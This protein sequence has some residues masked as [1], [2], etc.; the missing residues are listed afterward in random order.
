MFTKNKAVYLY[1]SSD[2][3]NKVIP[4]LLLPFISNYF[5][6]EALFKYSNFILVFTLVQAL[7]S[8]PFVSFL[9]VNLIKDKFIY[10]NGL[11]NYL[12]FWFTFVAFTFVIYAL[13]II[14]ESDSSEVL[15]WIALGCLCSINTLYFSLLQI[16]S[17][18]IVFFISN[19][20]RISFFCITILIGI[21][22]DK[23]DLEFIIFSF[24]ASYMALSLVS[25][26]YVYKQINT[27][28]LSFN[29]NFFMNMMKF[30]LPLLP[31]IA[32]SP[33]R[34]ALDR[35]I[36]MYISTTAIAG[37]YAG[38]YQ[39]SS[40]VQMFSATIIKSTIPN[41]SKCLNESNVDGFFKLVISSYK[42]LT[43]VT[44]V[45]LFTI[46]C[47]VPMLMG[48]DFAP[49]RVFSLLTL[50]FLFQSMSSFLTIYFQFFDKTLDLLKINIISVFIYV[51]VVGL[52]SLFGITSF[53]IGIVIASF[54]SFMYIY[55]W[56][57][58]DAKNN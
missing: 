2:L 52:S 6:T 18:V 33:A 7:F 53:A 11:L 34:T 54:I 36:L 21:Y 57:R 8:T 30:G 4:F 41:L 49:Y 40:V 23:V 20:A 39:M 24:L 28:K 27:F 25:I 17:K 35:Y 44:F 22:L 45:F 15:L 47:F 14:V 26:R 12:L 19:L 50:F 10:Q 3:L 55:I 31:N 5:G 13:L 32:L 51:I 43:A 29:L 56:V 46:F 37:V 38:Y 48:D 1:L 58:R 42:V 16:Q 9:T